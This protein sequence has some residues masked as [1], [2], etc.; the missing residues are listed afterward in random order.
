MSYKMAVKVAGLMLLSYRPNGIDEKTYVQ[1]VAMGLE[2]YSD[3]MLEALINPKTGII[4]KH[5]FMPSL[6]EMHEFCSN[7]GASTYEPQITS[8]PE[9]AKATEEEKQFATAFVKA[10]NLGFNGGDP[11]VEYQNQMKIGEKLTM[12]CPKYIKFCEDY[13]KR[14]K[15][16]QPPVSDAELEALRARFM[17]KP[18]KLSEDVLRTIRMPYKDE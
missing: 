8:F 2:D 3:D 4:A 18:A 9:P 1:T 12:D 17:A 6:A 13:K 11:F 14:G 10:L 5:K 15:N 16:G 7:Y